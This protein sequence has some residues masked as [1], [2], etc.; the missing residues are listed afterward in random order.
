[1]QAKIK[2]L[3]DELPI[4]EE[5]LPEM[6]HNVFGLDHGKMMSRLL[7]A[8]KKTRDAWST[9][10]TDSDVISYR[11]SSNT[12]RDPAVVNQR[13][14]LADFLLKRQVCSVF[15]IQI[16]SSCLYKPPLSFS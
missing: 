10:N 5:P 1:M 9:L 16:N 4:A 8:R 11:V 6:T 2:K 7:A 14:E 15:P 3:E 12:V 13:K